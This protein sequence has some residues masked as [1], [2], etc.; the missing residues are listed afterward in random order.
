MKTLR[1]FAS[2][3]VAAR[4]RDARKAAVDFI[5][6]RGSEMVDGRWKRLTIV[7]FGFLNG[8]PI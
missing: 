7:D 6:D 4:S 5:V 8:R 1:G 2:A 3:P